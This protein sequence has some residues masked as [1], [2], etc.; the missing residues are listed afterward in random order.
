MDIFAKRIQTIA[1]GFLIRRHLLIPSAEIQTKNWRKHRTWYDNGKR[2]ECELYQ[3]N[4]IERITGETCVKTDIRLNIITKNKVGKKYPM[5]DLD[6]FEWTEDFDGF[7]A[8]NGCSFYFNLKMICDSGGV[9]TRSLREVYHFVDVQLEHLLLHNSP[10]LRFINILDGDNCFRSMDKFQYLLNKPQYA[11][12]R[13][14]VF[15]GDM[16][17]FQSLWHKHN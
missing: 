17:Q 16:Q 12:V 7:I 9:Q 8:K 14:Q 4:V 10:E 1:R 11:R 6:G 15:V 5:K 13:N 2:N 3:R